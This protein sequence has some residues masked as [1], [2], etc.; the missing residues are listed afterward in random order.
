MNNDNSDRY[1]ESSYKTPSKNVMKD[2][3]YEQSSSV[4]KKETDANDKSFDPNF[5]FYKPFVPK[6][7][8]D[9]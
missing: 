4:I 9:P 2:K 8:I 5:T 1:L 7:N 6:D 3:Y